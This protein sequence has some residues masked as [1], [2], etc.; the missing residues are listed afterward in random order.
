M[1]TTTIRLNDDLKARISSI[2]DHFGE[3]AHSF[4]LEAITKRVAEEEERLSFAAIAE[5]RYAKILATGKAIP[6]DEM[7]RYLK[8]RF[9]DDP[10]LPVPPLPAARNITL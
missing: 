6:W 3:T 2:A 5:A 8:A 10:N 4:M 9:S 7:R 1:S